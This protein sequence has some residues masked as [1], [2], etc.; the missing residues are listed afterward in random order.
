MCVP[1]VALSVLHL[2]LACVLLL[3]LLQ[4][5]LLLFIA[6]EVQRKWMLWCDTVTA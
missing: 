3:L 6:D 1:H 5:F 2:V 4:L